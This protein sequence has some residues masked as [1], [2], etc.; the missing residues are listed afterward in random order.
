MWYI[1]REEI[2]YKCGILLTFLKI[3]EEVVGTI[4]YGIKKIHKIWNWAKRD[5]YV[6]DSGTD[7]ICLGSF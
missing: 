4:K 6:G 1:W 2:V 5:Q 7:Y 3:P